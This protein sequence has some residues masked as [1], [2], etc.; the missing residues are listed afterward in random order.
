MRS[1]RAAAAL[2]AWIVLTGVGVAK[3][4][5]L[6]TLDFDV[7]HL[8]GARFVAGSA[9][10]RDSDGDMTFKYAPFVAPLFAP[11]GLLPR[12]PAAIAWNLG[13]MLALLW[14]AAVALPKLH[15][16]AFAFTPEGALWSGAILLHPIFYE[17]SR[18]QADL[19]V[20]A[21][22]TGAVL[23]AST[24][25]GLGGALAAIAMGLK[26]PA[27]L[28]L[29]VLVRHRRW[30]AL[31]AA[32]AG[33]ALL[34]LVVLLRYGAAAP[35]LHQGWRHILRTTTPGI[36]MS[37]QGWI[38]LLVRA[39][40]V[41]PQWGMLALPAAA[42]VVLVAALAAARAA[43][44]TW[45]A[46]LALAIAAL[47][48]LCWNPNYVLA[49]PAL[50]LVFNHARTADPI[51]KWTAIGAGLAVAALLTALTPGIVSVAIYQR[52]LGI[53]RPYAWLSLALLVALFA[54][55]DRCAAAG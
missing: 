35:A 29:V 36:V 3:G 8:T 13:S 40:G 17:L 4:Y 43:P 52:V 27:A 12:R 7:F 23:Y 31:A 19:F 9:L 25:P 1:G 48:P 42:A 11:L 18:G 54:T 6:R 30:R 46:A 26:L 14:V 49:F 28:V 34:E 47:S 44:P 2:S 51:R 45:P 32:A 16:R 39:T 33:V 15:E 22:V 50:V 37:T 41:A 20:L 38:P 24:R 10:Y 53:F 21:A 5:T 55:R